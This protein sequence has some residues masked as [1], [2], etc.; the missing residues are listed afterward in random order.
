MNWEDEG[1]LLAK[2]K[3]RENA[4]IIDVFTISKGKISG[5]VYGGNSRKIRNYLQIGNKIFVIHNSKNDNKIGYLKT[6]L[7]EPISPKFFG[8]K[9]RTSAILSLT[10]LLNKLLPESQPYNK[11]YNSLIELYR[12]FEHDNWIILYI[13]WELNLIRELGYGT[14]LFK[15]SDSSLKN[16]DLANITVDNVNFTVPYFIINQKIPDEVANNL[17]L[18]SLSFTRSILQSKFFLP[19]NIIFPKSRIILENYYN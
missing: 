4:N 16:Y 15:F 5:I 10:F 18:K 12:N 11:I 14:N 17:I 2:R 1:F 9:K 19:N 7:I 6:E 3:F 8:D 13:F